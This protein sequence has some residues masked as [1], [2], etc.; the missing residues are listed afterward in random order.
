VPLPSRSL[1]VARAA[2]LVTE[3]CAGEGGPDRVGVELE[4]I[5]VRRG[6]GT[7]P[8]LATVERIAA[9][10]GRPPAGSRITLEPGGQL[11]VSAPP[12]LDLSDALAAAA[13]DAAALQGAA[14]RNGVALLARG[15]VPDQRERLLHTPRYD[16]MEAWYDT[17]HPAGRWMMRN[18]AA[19]QVNLDS[20]PSARWHAAVAVGP[21]LVAAFANSPA[22]GW[23]S[24]RMGWWMEMDPQYTVTPADWS[25]QALDAPVMLIRINDSDYRAMTTARSFRRWI[26]EGDPLGFPTEDDLRYHVTT[27]FPPV[28]CRGWLE[29][30]MLDALPSP[31]W[32]VATAVAWA[33]LAD[34]AVAAYA[35]AGSEDLWEDA[36]RFGLANPLLARAADRCFAAAVEALDGEWQ[37]AVAEY[38]DR[39][40]ARGRCPADDLAVHRVGA[41]SW[42]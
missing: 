27:L 16:A 35:S 28:R 39:F 17:R 36:A 29:L 19:L 26:E 10:T 14:D 42:T 37:A 41:R 31:W 24:R 2:D 23:K 30:R 13:S 40:V 15:S 20:G 33:V 32:E 6:D 9:D 7:Q 34:P 21:A 1:T 22:P 11:E 25:T 3:W 38:A 4:W 12:H 8:N 5:T 18:T